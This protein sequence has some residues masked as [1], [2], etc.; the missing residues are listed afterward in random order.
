[1]KKVVKLQHNNEAVEKDNLSQVE[2]ARQFSFELTD[3]KAKSNLIRSAGRMH[4][5][6]E[7][8]QKS[9]NL[10]CLSK[11]FCSHR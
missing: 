7:P 11:N 10:K 3:K 1:M 4:L 6:I 8:K 2:Y 9:S 5:E